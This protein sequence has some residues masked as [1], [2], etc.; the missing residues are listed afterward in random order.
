MGWWRESYPDKIGNK[1]FVKGIIIT[2][3]LYAIWHNGKQYI[4]VMEM[5]LEKAIEE[6]KKDLEY[7]KEEA[8]NG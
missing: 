7:E 8:S 6:V 5:P 1:D 4:G 3:R 2:M